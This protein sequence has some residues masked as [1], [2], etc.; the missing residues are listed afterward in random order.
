MPCPTCSNFSCFIKSQGSD[1]SYNFYEFP[2]VNS[3]IILRESCILC[4][5]FIHLY[6]PRYYQYGNVRT[7]ARIYLPRSHTHIHTH[8]RADETNEGQDYNNKDAGTGTLNS[9]GSRRWLVSSLLLGA[10]VLLRA[11]DPRCQPLSG[12]WIPRLLLAL[13]VTTHC[14]SILSQRLLALFSKHRA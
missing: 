4:I 10:N 7:S 13:C 5:Q 14:G 12:W 1:F 8:Q 2:H 6:I 9:S 11:C 3:Y